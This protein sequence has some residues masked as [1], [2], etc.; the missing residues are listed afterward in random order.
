MAEDHWVFH[1]VVADAALDIVVYIATADSS[2][3]YGDENVVGRGELGL[4]LLFEAD[5]EWFGEDE[6]EVLRLELANVS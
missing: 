1:D 3:V 4:G 5:L 6:G 2:V